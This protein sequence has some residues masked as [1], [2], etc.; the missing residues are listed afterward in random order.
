L[1]ELSIPEKARIVHHAGQG[2]S[3]T[4]MR[5]MTRLLAVNTA[6]VGFAGSQGNFEI[7][8]FKPVIIYNYLA[9]GTLITDAC[10]GYDRIQ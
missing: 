1:G 8:V 2:Q 5:S 9:L 3:Q 10:H 6:A 4:P 7:N